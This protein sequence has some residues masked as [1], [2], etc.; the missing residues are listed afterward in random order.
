M[1]KVLELRGLRSYLAF[2]AFNSLML[3][4]KMLPAHMSE[5]YEEFFTRVQAMQLED[6]V[7]VIREAALLVPMPKDDLE[8]LVSFCTDKNG[9]PYDSTNMGNLGPA[10]IFEVVVAVCTE[11]AKIKVTLISEDEKKNFGISQLT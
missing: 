11:L 1:R 7:K 5:T 10:E 3:G 6:Q 4:V 8:L 2:V 9:I